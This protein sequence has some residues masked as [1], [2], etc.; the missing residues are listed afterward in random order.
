MSN[1]NYKPQIHSKFYWIFADAWTLTARSL[2]HI[3]KNMDQLLG[4]F[5]QPVMFLLL[6]RYVFGSAIATGTTSYVNFLVAGILVQMAAF[7]GTMTAFSV[8]SDLTKGIIERLKSLP[9]FSAGVMTGHVIAD[10]VRNLIS[11]TVMILV[12]L[13]VGLRPDASPLEWLMIIGIILL[14]TLA[15]SWMS[16]ILALIAKSVEAVQWMSFL[17]VFPLTFAS[18][19]FVPAEGM[20]KYLRLFAENQPVT[21]VIDAIRSLM[22]GTPMGNSGWLAVVW[23]LGIT[24]IAIPIAAYLFRRSN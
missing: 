17:V 15:I 6:F 10:L 22:V 5:V 18:S 2:K 23:C 16:A 11:S 1:T 24:I 21:H 13:L 4:M 7:G 9:T 3:F 14:F 8:A 12:G 20:P 19:A